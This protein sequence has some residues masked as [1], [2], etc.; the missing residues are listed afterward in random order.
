M[1]S[2]HLDLYVIRDSKPLKWM[3]D[4]VARLI[5]TRASLGRPIIVEGICVLDVLDQITQSPDFLVYVRGEGGQ[6]LS[7]SLASYGQRWKPVERAHYVL[8]GFTD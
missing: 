5:Q 1:P 7:N 4:E 2:V 3:T 6:T 8:D